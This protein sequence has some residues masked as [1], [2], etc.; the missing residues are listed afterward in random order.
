MD[1]AKSG[2]IASGI[3][4][5]TDRQIAARMIESAKAAGRITPE[6]EDKQAALMV[7]TFLCGWEGPGFP[8]IEEGKKP[9]DYLGILAIDGVTNVITENLNVLLGLS[10]IDKKN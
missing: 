6:D 4:E 10:V 7:D 3:S 8:V 1:Q 2:L 9:S 5:P